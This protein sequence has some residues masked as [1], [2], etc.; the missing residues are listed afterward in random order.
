[1]Q[2]EVD[3]RLRIGYAPSSMNPFSRILIASAFAATTLLGTHVSAQQSVRIA[4]VDTRRAIEL[5][6]DGMRASATLKKIFDSR[7]QEL[8]RKEQDLMKQREEIDRQSR[9]VSKEALQKRLED[10][11]RQTMELQ[12]TFVEYNKELQKKERELLLPVQER[13]ITTIRRLA[14][15]DGFDVIVDK[16]NVAFV[17]TDLDLTDRVIQMVN[18]G[19]VAR[20]AASGSAAPAPPAPPA[21]PPAP[22]P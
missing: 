15:Q 4:V 10:W 2:A 6:E 7:Q 13:V 19:G 5:S 8:S 3:P 1:M 14:A 16:A 17:R 21:P 12:A 20:P 11:Q 9:V 18:G 22:K